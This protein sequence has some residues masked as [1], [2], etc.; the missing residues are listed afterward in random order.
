M[1]GI[2]VAPGA[3]AG[4]GAAGIEPAICDVTDADALASAFAGC[5]LVIHTAAHVRE[6]GEM[7]EFVRVNVGGTARVLDAAKA[8]GVDRVVH[9]SSVVVYGYD[10]AGEQDETAHLRSYGIP[11]IDT[12]S[13]SDRLARRRGAIVVRPGDVYG[14]GSIPWLV[15]PLELARAGRLAV[16]DSGDGIMLPAY[17]DDLVESLVAASERGRPGQ[18]YTVWDGEPVTFTDYF[19]RIAEI[20]GGAPPR[21]L[22]RPVLDLAGAAMERWARARGTAPSFTS[23][24]ATFIDRRGTVSIERARSELGWEP[25]V[26]LDEGLRRCA[27]WARGEGLVPQSRARGGSAA[28]D[29]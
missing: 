17:V 28:L 13:A 27:D 11:Y 21:R 15:R 22:P 2:D 16:P 29:D 1:V 14:P 26:G 5:D 18:A 19:T 23:R 8:A 4:L 24:S 7:D 25:K 20:A 9:V 12:K 3:A 10:A 6:W